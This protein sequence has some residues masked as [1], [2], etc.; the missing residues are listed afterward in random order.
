MN[1]NLKNDSSKGVRRSCKQSLWSL[2]R[3]S[4]GLEQRQ[5]WGLSDEWRFSQSCLNESCR[6]PRAHL[7]RV[8]TERYE[9][10]TSSLLCVGVG[11]SIQQSPRF[12]II[13]RC[14]GYKGVIKVIQPPLNCIIGKGSSGYKTH[15]YRMRILLFY[16]QVTRPC[17]CVFHKTLACYIYNNTRALK[18]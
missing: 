1:A 16:M 12:I 2:H 8:Y 7:S 18:C 5:T 15:N 13:F 10:E 3:M 17:A 11:T 4:N 6:H 9:C 14:Q